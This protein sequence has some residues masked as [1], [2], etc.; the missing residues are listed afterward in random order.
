MVPIWEAL[1]DPEYPG[2]TSDERAKMQ[3]AWGDTTSHL[4]GSVDDA[5][6]PACVRFYTAE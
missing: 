6:G 4:G 3:Q 1:G 5:R 2:I